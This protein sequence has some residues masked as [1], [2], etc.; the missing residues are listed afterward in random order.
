MYQLGQAVY[1]TDTLPTP[2][3]TKAPSFYQ[4]LCDSSV[5][6][7][8]CAYGYSKKYVNAYT[9]CTVYCTSEPVYGQCVPGGSSCTSSCRT[10]GELAGIIIGSVFSFF[11]LVPSSTSGCATVPSHH[12]RSNSKAMASAATKCRRLNILSPP[13]ELVGQFV[14]HLFL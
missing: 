11:F 5:C 3:P 7:T 14:R 4:D 8:F 10:A 13:C 1:T 2:S 12:W 6:P 9:G